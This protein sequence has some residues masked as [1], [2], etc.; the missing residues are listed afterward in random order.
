MAFVSKSA[1][2]I[3]LPIVK[4]PQRESEVITRDFN[5]VAAGSSSISK[6]LF[7]KLLEL[8]LVRPP[9]PAE[10]ACVTQHFGETGLQLADWLQWAYD[11]A[12]P[13]KQP[14]VW[15]LG[16]YNYGSSGMGYELDQKHF[17]ELQGYVADVTTELQNKGMWDGVTPEDVTVNVFREGIGSL[18]PPEGQAVV[19]KLLRVSGA[20]VEIML[21][22]GQALSDAAV[23]VPLLVRGPEDRFVVEAM[24]LGDMCSVQSPTDIEDTARLMAQLHRTPIDWFTS[25]HRELLEEACPALKDEPPSTAL[26]VFV[27]HQMARHKILDHFPQSDQLRS[28]LDHL[29][30][31]ASEHGMKLVSTHGDFWAANIR[32]PNGNAVVTDFEQSCVSAAATDLAHELHGKESIGHYLRELVG[33][34]PTEQEVY[35]LWLDAKIANFLEFEILRPVFMKDSWGDSPNPSMPHLIESTRRF[36]EVVVA[37]RRDVAVAKAA[38]DACPDD[39]EIWDNWNL[40]PWMQDL[41]DAIGGV[42]GGDAAVVD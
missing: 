8:H 32:M 3:T 9:T 12:H 22:C 11:S 10:V 5:A 41:V 37:L 33:R 31:P 1:V 30:R 4:W 27:A 40:Q 13:A 36:N 23:A 25:R 29:P 24:A 20:Q 35:D 7:T 21:D 42:I 34:E 19:L 38:L 14:Y 2:P 15:N 6:E 26:Y 17:V 28:L 16:L 39:W 18:T